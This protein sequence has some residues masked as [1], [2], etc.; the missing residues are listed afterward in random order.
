MLRSLPRSTLWVLLAALAAPGCLKSLDESLLDA[1]STGGAGGT[2]AGGS[3]GNTGGSGGTSPSGGTGGTTGGAGGTDADASDGA[4][5]TG[6]GSGIV[7]YDPVKYP[8]TNIGSGT[9]PVIITADDTHVV[10]ASKNKPDATVVSQPVGGGSGASLPPV[11]RPQALALD[12]TYVFVA[13]GRNIGDTGSVVRLPRAGG[14]K[15]ELTVPAMGVASGIF[16]APDGY[17]YVSVSAVTPGP[18]LLRFQSTATSTT[19][20]YTSPA[21]S[22]PA[23][24]LAVQD[25]CVYFVMSGDIWVM[26]VSGGT[27]AAA[28]TAPITDA[29]GLTTDSSNFYYTRGDG[30]VWRRALSSST[31]DGGGPAEAQLTSGFVA[32]G[33]LVAF[34]GKVAWTAMGDK[35][36]S[37]AGG[38]V[39]FISAG[40]GTVT[41]MAPAELG[42]IDIEQNTTDVVYATDVGPVRKVPKG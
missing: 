37:Y 21:G 36:K 6:A 28:L 42:P 18:G 31:C 8:V 11:E 7:P 2:D 35:A 19:T 14:P 16:A 38:G 29:V 1:K 39:F 3:G 15:Q 24:D 33:D 32:I 41:Q 23:G 26:P 20:L 25:P 13:G 30:S 9:P 4:G 12:P 5:G 22:E 34:D 40:G 10:R 17:V 27:R